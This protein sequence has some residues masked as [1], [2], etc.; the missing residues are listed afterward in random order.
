MKREVFYPKLLSSG[1]AGGRGGDGGGQENE[2]DGGL[3]CDHWEFLPGDIS[4]EIWA[5]E[6]DKDTLRNAV[7]LSVPF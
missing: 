6:S 5:C 3:R 1:D 2:R 4:V 7:A